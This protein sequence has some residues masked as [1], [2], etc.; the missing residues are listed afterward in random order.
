MLALV[1]TPLSPD[2]EPE[3]VPAIVEIKPVAADTFLT[4]LFE[5]SEINMFP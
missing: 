3:P 4:L 2:V 1:A 5:Q